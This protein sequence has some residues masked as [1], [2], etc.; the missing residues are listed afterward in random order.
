MKIGQKFREYTL[1]KMFGWVDRAFKGQQGPVECPHAGCSER[2]ETFVD[3]F[4]HQRD[5][6]A[7]A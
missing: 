2:F 7:S 1:T 6:H 5:S 3:L 4:K